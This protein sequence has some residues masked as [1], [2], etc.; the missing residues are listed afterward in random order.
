MNRT[1]IFGVHRRGARPE[2]LEVRSLLA[3]FYVNQPDDKLDATVLGDGIVDTDAHTDGDQISLRA[4]VQEANSL[5]GDDTI[6]LPPGVFPLSLG[7]LDITTEGTSIVGFTT[8]ITDTARRSMIVNAEDARNSLFVVERDARLT[9]NDVEL[10][11]GGFTF[12]GESVGGAINSLG[13]LLLLNVDITNSAASIGGGIYNAGTA[14]ID[15]THIK[16]NSAGQ[17]GG[18][19]NDGV[20]V[21]RNSWIEGN[22]ALDGGGIF[23]AAG[24]SSKGEL[25][26]Q[27]TTIS[28]NHAMGI[29]SGS[30][31]GGLWNSGSL[32]M[33]NSTISANSSTGVGGGIYTLGADFA[34]FVELRQTTVTQNRAGLEN[35]NGG[36][37]I[38]LPGKGDVGL[39]NSI[40]ANNTSSNG[41]ASVEQDD[42][43]A[44]VNTLSSGNLIGVD[45]GL[46]G[47]VNGKQENLIGTLSSP[48]N[49]GLGPL[50]LNGGPTLTYALLRRSIA[51]DAGVALEGLSIDQRGNDRVVDGDGDLPALPGI[52]AFEYQPGSTIRGLVFEDLD[53]DGNYDMESDLRSEPGIEGIVV[54]LLG[55]IDGD[56]N[57]DS[58]EAKT[59]LAKGEYEFFDLSPGTYQ[60]AIT[61][62]PNFVPTRGVS[63]SVTADGS[64]LYVGDL[65]QVEMEPLESVVLQN[66]LVFG[67]ARQGSVRGFVYEDVLENGLGP[68][69]QGLPGAIVEIFSDVNNN[70]LFDTADTLLEVTQTGS[71]GAYAFGTLLPGGYFVRHAPPVNFI[72]TAPGGEVNHVYV[73]ITEN[74]VASVDFAD[75]GLASLSGKVFDDLTGNGVTLD[76]PGSAEAMV[77][78][79]FDSDGNG[80]F[81]S[82]LDS[83]LKEA[84]PNSAG[85]YG[86]EDLHA[87]RYFVTVEFPEG[88]LRTNGGEAFPQNTY[89]TITLVS[90]TVVIDQNF[91]SFGRIRAGGAAWS[92]LSLNGITSDDEPASAITIELLRDQGNGILD[93]DDSIVET[94]VTNTLGKY[95][96]KLQLTPGVYFARLTLPENFVYTVPFGVTYHT[97]EARSGMDRLDLDFAFAANGKIRG[98][99]VNNVGASG[100]SNWLVELQNSDNETIRTVRTD[101]NGDYEFLGVSPGDYQVFAQT[102]PNWEQ[103]GPTGRFATQNLLGVNGILSAWLPADV[104]QDGLVDIVGVL[105]SDFSNSQSASVYAFPN[106]GN[107]VWGDPLVQPLPAGIRPKQAIIAD[108]NGDNMSDVLIA[109]IGRGDADSDGVEILFGRGEYRFS[110]PQG[111]FPKTG[112]SAIAVGDFNNDD[113]LDV[114]AGGYRDNSVLNILLGTPSGLAVSA[115]SPPLNFAPQSISAGDVDGDGDD[116]LAVAS[117]GSSKLAFY[118]GDPTAVL[119]HDGDLTAFTRSH[120]VVYHDFDGDSKLDLVIATDEGIEFLRRGSPA[121]YALVGKIDLTESPRSLAIGD[122]NGDGLQDLVVSAS[123]ANAVYQLYSRGGFTYSAP[124]RLETAP[125]PSRSAQATAIAD[126]DKDGR[127]DLAVGHYAQIGSVFLNKPVRYSVSLQQGECVDKLD[128]RF[129]LL[130]EISEVASARNR[131]DVDDNE[132]ITSADVIYIVDYLNSQNDGIPE[133]RVLSLVD[134]RLDV[135]SNGRITQL[136]ALMVVDY[137]N[138][139]ADSIAGS[140]SATILTPASAQRDLDLVA[141]GIAITRAQ[142]D[143]FDISNPLAQDALLH[144]KG[145]GI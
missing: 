52:G 55:D 20:M 104:N 117:Q 9:L 111:Y 105:D 48:I 76:D 110:A 57:P 133:P 60:I 89:Y 122:L 16:G 108:V 142:G 139:R 54:T 30:H 43:F 88:R 44:S 74:A 19:Y 102:M 92:D 69:D 124:I 8:T 101:A 85:Q 62:P 58:V 42:V 138:E 63:T 135:D 82:I 65:F 128:F 83:K 28:D 143:S 41:E 71:D 78:L 68:D 145:R 13:T 127:L 109:N 47:I 140:L 11:R 64:K 1:S 22:S 144:R 34:A 91:A 130:G 75:F 115:V 131:L 25:T 56:G 116:D 15:Y 132:R 72:Q 90:R 3:T 2:R 53:V 31:G 39:F 80:V 7:Q 38:S 136:D 23:N 12:F 18:I 137:L 67:L 46:R 37:G 24:V 120:Q 87:G 119:V 66:S 96:F 70:K 106:L 93:L 14:T 79:Y 95:E 21:L 84:R 5:P 49:A 36:G 125:S 50:K 121:S 86:W 59:G 45:F 123:D 113:R 4:A 129:L 40:V 51:I 10:S 35:K 33:D 134:D 118:H 97:F 114:V 77:F 29:T 103:T 17:G 32:R 141:S 81:D 112:M 6:F 107:G 98:K 94:A 100:L 26:V 61:T 99:A 73:E 27:S 126:F